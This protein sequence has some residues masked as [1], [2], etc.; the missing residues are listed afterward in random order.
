MLLPLL[1]LLLLLLLKLKLFSWTLFVSCQLTF[2]ERS[3]CTIHS[4]LLLSSLLLSISLTL[5]FTLIHQASILKFIYPIISITSIFV[6]TLAGFT[7]PNLLFLF[8]IYNIFIPNA[9]LCVFLLAHFLARLI[10]ALVL[11]YLAF[12]F[13]NTLTLA[14]LTDRLYSPTIFIFCLSFLHF[15]II[16]SC[17]WIHWRKFNWYINYSKIS[18][19]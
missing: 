4:L 2:V 14:F 3:S 9:T 6:N 12:Y 5:H 7:C 19:L 17:F 16:T 13:F 1:L 8:T 10:N 15:S 11:F 18:Q